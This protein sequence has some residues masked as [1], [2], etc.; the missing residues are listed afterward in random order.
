MASGDQT[1]VLVFLHKYFT[2]KA[3]PR[4]LECHLPIQTSLKG[5]TA[6]LKVHTL[7]SF[8]TL[9]SPWEVADELGAEFS[10]RPRS[11]VVCLTDLL[12]WRTH[13]RQ[14]PR[15]QQ[16]QQDCEEDQDLG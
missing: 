15:H 8:V 6:V 2:G 11:P 12:P 4:V 1:Q 13:Q 7:G 5:P 14:C 3:V 10:V 16:H 9:L